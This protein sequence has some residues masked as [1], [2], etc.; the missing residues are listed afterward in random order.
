MFKLDADKGVVFRMHGGIGRS[1]GMGEAEHNALR[2]G[3]ERV[4]QLLAQSI[5][6][7]SGKAQT[8]D[9]DKAADLFWG[10]P[11]KRLS[12]QSVQHAAG[13]VVRPSVIAHQLKGFGGGDIGLGKAHSDKGH[14]NTSFLGGLR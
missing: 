1:V 10:L 8:V 9:G 13:I 12:Q 6:E 7:G 11:D 3:L 14:E 2:R 4:G 5:A